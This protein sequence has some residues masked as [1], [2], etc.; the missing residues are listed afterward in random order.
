L[1]LKILLHRAL[2][3]PERTCDGAQAVTLLAES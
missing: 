2:R 1:T 3:H